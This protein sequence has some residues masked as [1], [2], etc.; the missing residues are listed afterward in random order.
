VG[1]NCVNKSKRAHG[2]QAR[3]WICPDSGHNMQLDNPKALANILAHEVLGYQ[4][5]F[6]KNLPILTVK[7]YDSYIP[8]IL[9]D[10]ETTY[11][12]HFKRIESEREEKIYD[13][14]PR[15]KT[16]GFPWKVWKTNME[17][18]SIK[19]LIRCFFCNEYKYECLDNKSFYTTILEGMDNSKFK[20]ESELKHNEAF[21][22]FLD[23]E[24][25]LP[26]LE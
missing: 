21:D 13:L 9:S 11:D 16:D 22:Y 17:N 15:Y 10:V 19:H 23:L 26:T 25:E 6:D 20:F 3:Y 1:F 18:C 5:C 8:R 12:L 24:A 2:S 14:I 4:Y 7:E